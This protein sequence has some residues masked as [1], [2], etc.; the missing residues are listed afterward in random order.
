MKMIDLGEFRE[1]AEARYDFDYVESEGPTTL[2][3]D[4]GGQSAWVHASGMIEGPKF[5]HSKLEKVITG[6]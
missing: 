6:M 1:R 5:I 3:F 4:I 2:R